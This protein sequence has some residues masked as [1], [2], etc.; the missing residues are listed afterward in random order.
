MGWVQHSILKCTKSC[1]YRRKHREVSITWLGNEAEVNNDSGKTEKM[2][3]AYQVS[4][5][6][7]ERST[8]V[9]ANQV[10]T[11]PTIPILILE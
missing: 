5:G 1:H 9:R 3:V 8:G 2:I 4:V 6:I 11:K 10:N 7:T